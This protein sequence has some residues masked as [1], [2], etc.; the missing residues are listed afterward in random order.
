MF[1]AK[2]MTPNPITVE[3]DTSVMDAAD[4]MHAKKIRRLPVI[5]NGKLVGIV[6]DRDLREVGP[7]PATS[8]SV[9]EL[10]YLLAKMKI[11]DVMTKS[12]LTVSVDATI[13]EAALLMYKNKI[14]AVVAIDQAGKVVGIITETDIFKLFVDLMGLPSGMTR[15]TLDVTDQVGVLSEI[16]AIFRDEN[17]NIKSLTTFSTDGKAELVIRADV[18]DPTDLVEALKAKGYPVLHVARIKA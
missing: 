12:V 9:H 15:I 3:S 8:L 14:G 17:I 1:V 13:E 7:S 10:N 2:R 4:L 6:T 16:T 18:A 5:D 11:S